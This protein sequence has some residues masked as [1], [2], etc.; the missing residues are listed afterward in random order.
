MD[1]GDLLARLGC[2][3]GG[4]SILRERAAKLIAELPSEDLLRLLDYGMQEARRGETTARKVLPALV[5]ALLTSE[6][7]ASLAAAAS[8]ERLFSVVPLFAEGPPAKEYLAEAAARADARL[9]SLPLG[10][11][12]SK[13]RLSRNREELAKLAA[14]SQPSV[15]RELLKNPRATESLVVSIAAHRP[16]RGD[17][18]NELWRSPRWSTRAP[19]RRALAMNPYL[20]PEL[21]AVILP[22]LAD[23]DLRSIAADNALHPSVRAQA[24][25]LV[26]AS[27]R[28]AGGG[29]GGVTS[30]K[31][32][33]REARLKE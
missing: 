18:L 21:G 10:T 15:L 2:L 20:P 22:L 23:N 16:A 4:P 29:R 26:Q 25:Q 27:S 12:K 30:M 3:G 5:T 6:R 17:A 13:A 33:P 1:P 8:D 28:S 14:I 31:P 11:L 9:S 19:V 32:S 24:K 7:R